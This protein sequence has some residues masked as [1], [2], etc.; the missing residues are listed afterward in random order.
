M[1]RDKV[2]TVALK[3]AHAE[4][5]ADLT[6]MLPEI[7]RHGT[8]VSS[9]GEFYD[10]QT[11]DDDL[12]LCA[13]YDHIANGKV[14]AI[15]DNIGPGANDTVHEWKA[16]TF[17]KEAEKD[18]DPKL[19]SDVIQAY[20][21]GFNVND[22][23][24]LTGLKAGKIYYLLDKFYKNRKPRVIHAAKASTDDDRTS[25]VEQWNA[26]QSIKQIATS[27]GV[28]H[29]T[30]SRWLYDV[31]GKDAIDQEQ[32]NRRSTGGSLHI[33][34]KITPELQAKIKEL[35]LTGMSVDDIA[36][37]IDNVIAPRNVYTA[38]KR[39]PNFVELQAQRE[40]RKQK[41][42]MKTNATATIYRPGTIG[43]RRSKGA[44]NRNT[45]GVNWPKYG[46]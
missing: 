24:S 6:K 13:V 34:K 20:D 10:Q 37:A 28:D 7:A 43:N 8:A 4:L 29:T 46:E 17:I 45:W 22:M 44:G 42:K 26:G 23:M 21:L 12:V 33:S 40:E 35:Y 27:I 1:I 30:V 18:Y 11:F 39:E 25:A 32:Q 38:M 15:T 3:K 19:I 41:I 9:K 14:I 5:A 16:N 2:S 36:A 31:F